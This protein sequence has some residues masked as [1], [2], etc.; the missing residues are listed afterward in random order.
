MNRA[1]QEAEIL[2]AIVA[3]QIAPRFNTDDVVTRSV[4]MA[5]KIVDEVTRRADERLE[6]APE[7]LDQGIVFVDEFS[8]RNGKT[9]EDRR[10]GVSV[11]WADGQHV[12]VTGL[13]SAVIDA[14]EKFVESTHGHRFTVMYDRD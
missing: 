9:G 4:D 8:S 1:P 13:M 12:D 2:T 6:S 7:P 3:G 10:R 14:V 5:E 11:E